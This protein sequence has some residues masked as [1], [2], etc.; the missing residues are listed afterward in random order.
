[1]KYILHIISWSIELTKR[2]MMTNIYA[3]PLKEN[4]R[5]ST[6]LDFFKVTMWH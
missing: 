2:I 3:V 6:G 4:E 5:S 1:M